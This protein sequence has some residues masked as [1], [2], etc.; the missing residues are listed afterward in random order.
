MGA[1]ETCDAGS[2]DRLQFVDAHHHFQDIKSHY[3][4]WLCDDDAAPKLE[5]DIGPIRRNYLPEEFFSDL[6]S[7]R[8]IKSVHVQNGWDPSDPVG[9][10]RWLQTLADRTGFPNAIVAFA[11]LATPGVER[12]LAAHC[13]SANMRGIRQILNWH[14]D[15]ALRVAGRSDLMDDDAWRSG[16]ACLGKFA[17]SFDLQIYWTQWEQACR[18][19]RDFPGTTILLNHFG[20]PI[21]RSP[22]AIAGWEVALARLAEL[23][24]MMIKLSGV[25]L[26]HPAWTIDDTAPLLRRAIDIFG[27]ERAMFGTNLP[28]D[29]LFAKPTR[30]I[31]CYARVLQGFAPSERAALAMGNAERAYRIQAAG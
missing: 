30:I 10:T 17:L 8:L 3:Y 5:G 9:E 13:E 6:S 4:P 11:D 22:E 16:F 26:G 24:N 1:I 29:T 31:A 12:L 18:L 14:H 27:V 2:G 20:M 25:G 7:A 21:D 15:P 23:P 19:A 28:V